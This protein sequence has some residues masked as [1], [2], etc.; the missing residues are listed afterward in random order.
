MSCSDQQCSPKLEKFRDAYKEKYPCMT[1]STRGD[2][3][4]FCQICRCDIKVAHGGI[5]DLDN[6]VSTT[7]H[8]QS[9]EA[10]KKAARTSTKVTT[11]FTS[12]LSNTATINAEVKFTDFLVE[13]NLPLAA[14]DHAWPLF[15]QMFPDSNIAKE[16]SCARTKTSHIVGHLADCDSSNLTRAIK[17]APFSI[18]TDGSTDSEAVKLYPVLI[19]SFDEEMGR[20]V[21]ELLELKECNERSTG[22]NIFKLLDNALSSRGISWDKCVSFG[23]DNASVMTGK[24]KGV[25]AFL[26]AANPE[27]Y[28]LR[29]PCHLMHLAAK[30]GGKCLEFKLD[31][32]LVDVWYY[33]DKSQLRHQSLQQ[34]QQKHGLES[35]KILKHVPTRWLSLG[36]ALER[37]LE[38]WG[39]IEEFFKSERNTKKN[40]QSTTSGRAATKRKATSDSD[41][42]SKTSN[43]TVQ[44]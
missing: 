13:H 36:I 1:S 15:R 11:F 32:L 20:V 14:A 10:E 38:N 21:S 22:E 23:T 4:A 16:Y 18:A 2:L 30:Q 41:N 19:H 39:P 43:Q 35:K 5:T 26:A 8:I 34:L 28:I 29:C 37:L 7:K 24:Y 3:F 31:D 17:N 12:S 27:I 44:G 9:E 6:H 25:A 42:G 40:T 33:L